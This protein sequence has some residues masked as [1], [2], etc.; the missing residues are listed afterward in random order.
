MNDFE[1]LL[2]NKPGLSIEYAKK[3]GNQ[4]QRLSNRLTNLLQKDVRTRVLYF[5]WTLVQQNRAQ[6]GNSIYL[7]N[8]FTHE[9]IARLTGTTR[10]T[11][12]M[13]IN[14]FTEE[15]LLAVDRKQIVINDIKLLQK[16]I[17][18]G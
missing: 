5:F 1:Q 17:K 7:D 4:M 16:E 15:G 8:Y 11:V 6:T 13:L 2:N 18:V 3:V 9:D 14:Q 12:T 10:Q